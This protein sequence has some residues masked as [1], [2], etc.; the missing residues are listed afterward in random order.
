MPTRFGVLHNL[1]RMARGTITHVQEGLTLGDSR[2]CAGAG[3]TGSRCSLPRGGGQEYIAGRLKN[4][5]K[6]LRG[7]TMPMA[8][9]QEKPITRRE[10]LRGASAGLVAL[11]ISS[12]DE[13][14][15]PQAQPPN[16]VFI[17]ADDLGYADVSCYGR[18]AVSS[19]SGMTGTLPCSPRTGKV[20][21]PVSTVSSLL[22]TSARRKRT[23]CPTS[24]PRQTTRISFSK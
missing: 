7:G 24:P 17:L 10:L 8:L 14:V 18:P 15:E 13:A 22:T 21:R 6:Q 9:L 5:G 1:F 2:Q 4:D 23:K 16:I 3:L 19:G 11:A 12:E 20:S